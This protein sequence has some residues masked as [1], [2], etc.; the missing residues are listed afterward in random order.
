MKILVITDLYAPRIGGLEGSVEWIMSRVQKLGNEV[1]IVA[2]RNPPSLPAQETIRGMRVRRLFFIRPQLNPKWLLGLVAIPQ[3]ISLIKREKPDVVSV[4]FPHS[5]A[6]ASCFAISLTQVPFVITFH[7]NDAAFLHTQRL[8]RIMGAHLIRN[9]KAVTGVSDFIV[10]KLLPPFTTA[11]IPIRSAIDV[12]E[13]DS[14]PYSKEPVPARFIYA[15][16]RFVR[17]K[18]FDILIRAFAQ[19]NLPPEIKL[20]I[21]G[22]GPE[23]QF[24]KELSEKL[25][26]SGRAILPGF[27]PRERLRQLF[28]E[29]ELYVVPSREEPLGAVVMEAMAA[30]KPIVATD[31]GGIPERIKDGETGLL[32][33]PEASDMA[34]K[35]GWMLG[36]PHHARQM[37]LKARKRS[38]QETPEKNAEDYVKVF[39][40]AIGRANAK[41]ARGAR[42][43][44]RN[45]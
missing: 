8:S 14:A 17:K 32:C 29:C 40:L 41:K 15:T 7:G 20:V 4:H 39:Q 19:A 6:L 2:A 43:R 18:G 3:L 21:T 36:H 42:E 45:A 31:V 33:K 28:R 16:G 22:D 10:Q 35:L 5:N 12:S 26:L 44:K 38:E 1:L 24:C 25:G 23:R 37:G 27:A 30:R 34:D 13:F 11:G 9:A